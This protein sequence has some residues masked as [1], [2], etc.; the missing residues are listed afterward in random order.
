MN[1]CH[2]LGRIGFTIIFIIIV[3]CVLEGEVLSRCV[4]HGDKIA[5][6][7]R[8]RRVIYGRSST[9]P[10]WIQEPGQEPIII[11]QIK[12]AVV[13]AAPWSNQVSQSAKETTISS[14]S[15][16]SKPISG[17][18]WGGAL[19]RIPLTQASFARRGNRRVGVPTTGDPCSRAEFQGEE[20]CEAKIDTRLKRRNVREGAEQ[21]NRFTSCAKS[22]P[23]CGALR[24]RGTLKM[25]HRYAAAEAI[26]VAGY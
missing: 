5:L 24:P 1:V 16:L 26:G 17:A 10:E 3:L 8:L 6:H 18:S 14:S 21:G 2:Q 4:L 12:T 15:P 7:G 9:N 19:K 23:S 11:P 25:C 22:T 13:T 20:N